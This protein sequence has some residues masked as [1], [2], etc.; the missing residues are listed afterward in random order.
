MTA[1]YRPRLQIVCFEPDTQTGK[2]GYSDGAG[3]GCFPPLDR[4]AW[5]VLYNATNLLHA[6]SASVML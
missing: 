3:V 4:Q 2:A 1:R 6:R 5:S